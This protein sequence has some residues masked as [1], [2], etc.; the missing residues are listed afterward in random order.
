VLS[1][2][3][4]FLF[5]MSTVINSSF[6][7][8]QRAN[9]RIA[10]TVVD[11]LSG[12]PL[13]NAEVSITSATAPE[14]ARTTL[15]SS[16]GHFLFSN[17]PAGKY[18]VSGRHNGY[19]QQNFHQ[20][21]GY[22][23]AI[24]AGP[25]QNSE[26]LRFPL[27]RAA[28]IVGSVTDELSDPIRGAEIILFSF[29]L[30]GGSR[31]C[32]IAG[33]TTTDDLGRYRFAH[34]LAGNYAVM[35]HAKPW[36]VNGQVQPGDLVKVFR[37]AVNPTDQGP[38][39]SHSL[40][41]P[42]FDVV[43]PIVFYPNVPSLAE[44]AKLTLAAGSMET[45][46]FALRSVPSIHLFIRTPVV[47]PATSHDTGQPQSDASVE[48]ERR[49][50]E[51]SDNPVTSIR[52][53]APGLSELSGIPPGE[54]TVTATSTVNNNT[55]VWSQMLDLSGNRDI[56]LSP[57]GGASDISG[58]VLFAANSSTLQSLTGGL[59]IMHDVHQESSTSDSSS[60]DSSDDDPP[61]AEQNGLEEVGDQL[62]M[63]I[64]FHSAKTGES[65][66][67]YISRNG[68]FSMAG[69]SIPAGT[70]EINFLDLSNLQVTSV[71]SNGKTTSGRTVDVLSGQPLKLVIHT[72]EEKCTVTGVAL[73]DGKPFAGAMMLLVPQDSHQNPALFHRDQSDSDGT[74]NMSPIFP[75]HYTAIEDGWDLEWASAAVLFKYLPNGIPV[76]LKPDAT[77]TF[78]VSVQ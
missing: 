49:V 7:S 51:Y 17:L 13:D 8:P 64:F 25:G 4:I 68:S 44:A 53:I 2:A 24:V 20:H 75:G 77:A 59:Q 65:F 22:S 16:D 19:V 58:T 41:N 76:D 10:G 14:D 9:Y 52:E 46:D 62:P 15:T 56:D 69:A 28:F 70:Y 1:R 23:T 38:V 43:Y 30:S 31:T 74:F 40:A 78:K 57:H 50:G 55:S 67:S 35:V 11:S 18:A 12:Q 66:G 72:A 34:L 37:G 26:V 3:T 61:V 60:S 73:K 48:V 32:H 33:R 27:P 6:A 21:E 63:Q 45:A 39:E 42:L 36:Y 71:E 29:G 5:L 47:L 54:V